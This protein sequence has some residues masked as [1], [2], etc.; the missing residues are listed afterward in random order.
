[1]FEAWGTHG[2]NRSTVI[3]EHPN[4]STALALALPARNA[5]PIRNFSIVAKK[6]KNTE[7]RA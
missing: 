2:S 7:M 5:T 4:R 3:W 1:M 6:R